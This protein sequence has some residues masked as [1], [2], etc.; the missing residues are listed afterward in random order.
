MLDLAVCKDPYVAELCAKKTKVVVILNVFRGLFVF[1]GFIP[2]MRME[3]LN[4]V[5]C[6]IFRTFCTDFQIFVSEAA[7]SWRI[8]LW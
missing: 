7:T 2:F 1:F 8:S 5:T 4:S 6:H 3:R